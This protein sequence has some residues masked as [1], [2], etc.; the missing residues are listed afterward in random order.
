MNKTGK[1]SDKQRMY[2][3]RQLRPYLSKPGESIGVVVEFQGVGG[4]Y[5]VDITAVAFKW[6]FINDQM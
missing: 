2:G 5:Q 6:C 4:E 3:L 1:K